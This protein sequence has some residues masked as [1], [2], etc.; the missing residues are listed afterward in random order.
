[1]FIL[2]C[3]DREKDYA[4]MNR[5][6]IKKNINSILYQILSASSYSLIPILSSA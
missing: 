3:I 6:I 2:Q 1:M 5:N 4:G